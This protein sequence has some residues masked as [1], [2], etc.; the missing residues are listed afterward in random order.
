MNVFNQAMIVV[1]SI[2]EDIVKLTMQ[3]YPI[4]QAPTPCSM[5][6]CALRK[7]II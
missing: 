3:P 5:L 2:S 1:V 6:V 4:T 7:Y